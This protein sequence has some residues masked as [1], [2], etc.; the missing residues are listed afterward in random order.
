MECR[1]H[2]KHVHLSEERLRSL[3]TGGG[4]LLCHPLLEEGNGKAQRHAYSTHRK[5]GNPRI[6]LA[7]MG[8]KQTRPRVPSHFRINNLPVNI[9]SVMKRGFWNWCVDPSRP[10]PLRS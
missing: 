6:Q 7:S 9:V 8:G 10:S 1:D 3:P 5:C 4:I 2:P